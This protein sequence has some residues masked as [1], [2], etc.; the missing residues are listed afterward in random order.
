MT[1]GL[2]KKE[3]EKRKIRKRQRVKRNRKG[4]KERKKWWVTFGRV[5][6][7]L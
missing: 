6:T 4:K 5:F 1:L 7:F 3:N 2:S